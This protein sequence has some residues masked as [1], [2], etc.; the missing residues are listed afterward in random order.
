MKLKEFLLNLGYTP[1][2]LNKTNTNHFEIKVKINKIKGKFILDT[3]A[4]NS[5]LG[6][7]AIE[8]FI[9]ETQDSDH[10]ASGA[11]SN[12]LKTLISEKNTIKIGKFKLK[13]YPLIL[14]DLKH[15]NQALESQNANRVDGIIGADILEKGKA[16]IDYKKKNLFLKIN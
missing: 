8:K 13:K 11:G 1:I 9:L 15:V 12:D 10:K 5:C 7:E 16:I 4:S 14:I 2:K 3:G 6:F